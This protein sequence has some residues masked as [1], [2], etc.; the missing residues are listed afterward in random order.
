MG[1]RGL[2]GCTWR[3]G[4]GVQRVEGR[5]VDESET[6]YIHRYRDGNY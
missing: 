3:A 5:G 2:R 6:G 1:L 4:C